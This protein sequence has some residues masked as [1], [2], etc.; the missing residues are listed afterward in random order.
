MNT[1]I[2]RGEFIAATSQTDFTFNFK[3]FANSDIKV[4]Q[5]ATGEEPNDTNDLITAYTVVIDGDNGGT[6]TLNT[7]ATNLDIVTVVRDLPIE[8]NYD[9][10][11]GADVT[12]DTLDEDQDYQTYLTLDRESALNL[13]FQDSSQG[14]DSKMPTPSPENYFRWSTDGKSIENDTTAPQFLIDTETARDVAVAS[15]VSAATS[16]T[17]A[18]TSETNASTSETNSATSET[19]AQLIAWEAEAEKMTAD[20]YATEAEDVLVNAYTSDGDGTF[21]A[22]PTTDYSSFHWQEKAKSIA[23]VTADTVSY[24][25]TTSGITA[26]NVQDAIDEIVQDFGTFSPRL[27]DATTGGN[28]SPTTATYAKYVKK[29]NEVTVSIRFIDIDKTGMTDA[30]LLT[31]QGLPFVSDTGRHIG[32]CRPDKITLGTGTFLVPFANSNVDYIN[33]SICESA[34]A[35]AGLLVSSIGVGGGSDIELVLTYFI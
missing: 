14:M 15:A 32:T 19:N 3:I 35:D 21:T 7:G 29:E 11:R 30:N 13:R 10:K 31:L 25:N 17:N 20:S 6:V 34:V 24:D 9:Y 22:T 18:A 4:Y 12:A 33:F 16:A 5:R 26:V 8:R 2:G 23:N 1:N 28:L 27:S